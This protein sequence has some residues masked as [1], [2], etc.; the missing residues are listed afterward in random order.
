MSWR[1][2]YSR[3][4]GGQLKWVSLI[5]ESDDQFELSFCSTNCLRTYLNSKV[6]ALENEIQDWYTDRIRYVSEENG[7]SAAVQEWCR[8]FGCSMEEA[9]KALNEL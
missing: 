2:P 4:E 9:E 1:S 3:G 5:E 7:R 8:Y 6:K